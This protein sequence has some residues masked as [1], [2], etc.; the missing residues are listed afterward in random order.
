MKAAAWVLAG[1]LLLSAFGLKAFSGNKLSD[2]QPVQLLI[3]QQ[4]PDGVAVK[5][6]NGLSGYGKDYDEAMQ[7]LEQTAPGKAFFASC[8]A[9]VLCGGKQSLRAVLEDAR[10]RP[11][12]MVYAAPFAPE[13]AQLQPVIAAHPGS[14]RIADFKG[15]GEEP[16]QL[17]P[18]AEGW[19]V[20]NGS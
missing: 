10:L 5:T 18:L 19:M 15:G 14:V 16:T 12:A 17:I 1:Y 13:P 4:L 20:E 3:V 8:N 7:R 9:V 2:L 11:A 6:D